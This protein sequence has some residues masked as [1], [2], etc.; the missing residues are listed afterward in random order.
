ML[1]VHA[2]L[3]VSLRLAHC[4]RTVTLASFD[5][6]RFAQA[7]ARSRTA[8]SAENLFLRKQLGAVSGTEGQATRGG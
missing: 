5:L 1:S 2:T 7:E 8:L 4:L 6:A 3:K